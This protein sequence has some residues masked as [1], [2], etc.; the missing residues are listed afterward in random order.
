[1]MEFTI[2]CRA[3]P[4]PEIALAEGWADGGA[5]RLGDAGARLKPDAYQ[6]AWIDWTV[7]SLT[8]ADLVA[9]LHAVLRAA[10]RE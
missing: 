9:E 4:E 6:A 8:P 1:M 5:G 10:R 3:H 2:T 7:V